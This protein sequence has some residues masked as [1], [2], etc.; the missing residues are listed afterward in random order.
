MLK[1]VVDRYGTRCVKDSF[2][3][4]DKI[5]E[6][7]LSRDGHMCSFDIVSLFT[8]VPLHEVIDICAELLYH[9]QT[10]ESPPPSI[11]EKSFR[12]LMEKV[13]LGVEFLFNGT[14]YR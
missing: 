7:A 13:T 14:M 12:E 11:S 9:D 8:N 5:K 3:F 10:N 6:A 1:P 2:T 4:S